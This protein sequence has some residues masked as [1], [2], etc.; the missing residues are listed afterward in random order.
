MTRQEEVTHPGE[1]WSGDG[2]RYR[3]PATRPVPRSRSGHGHGQGQGGRPTASRVEHTPREET[4][5]LPPAGAAWAPL[6]SYGISV[7]LSWLPWAPAACFHL[8]QKPHSSLR[9]SRRPAAYDTV[10]WATSILTKAHILRSYNLKAPY[11]H[12]PLVLSFYFALFQ[13][14]R[15]YWKKS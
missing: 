13:K 11:S 14:Y 1:A 8:P 4:A 12:S 5:G 10:R 15:I 2:D 9:S 6:A 3:G 7:A